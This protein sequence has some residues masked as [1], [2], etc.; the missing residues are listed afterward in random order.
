[1]EKR[2]CEGVLLEGGGSTGSMGKMCERS[3][4]SCVRRMRDELTSWS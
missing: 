1:M 4:M 2:R 3:V